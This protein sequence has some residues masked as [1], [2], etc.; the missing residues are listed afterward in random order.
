MTQTDPRRRRLVKRVPILSLVVVFTLLACGGGDSDIVIVS[1]G[2]RSSGVVSAGVPDEFA[3]AAGST[4][5]LYWIEGEVKNAGTEPVT[6]VTITFRTTDGN[7]KRLFIAEAGPIPPGKTVRY[8]SDRYP[9]PL[10]IQLLE[11]EPDIEIA[12]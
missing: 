5:E 2:V 7:S 3:G 12:R 4:R 10:R 6:K 9:S 8:A 1:K 11:D